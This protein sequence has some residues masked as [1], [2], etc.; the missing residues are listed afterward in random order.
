M[1]TFEVVKVL[2]FF[3]ILV[4]YIQFLLAVACYKLWLRFRWDFPCAL[5]VALLIAE[6]AYFSNP[7][8][9]DDAK[10]PLFIIWGVIAFAIIIPSAE[11]VERGY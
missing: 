2:I 11:L 4:D 8:Q 1:T 6:I 7:Q 5:G 9:W 3:A 10:L